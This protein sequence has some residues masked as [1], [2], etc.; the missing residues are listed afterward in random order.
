M[1]NKEI[2][3]GF[4][5]EGYENKNYDFVMKYVADNYID[6]SPANARSNK[7]AVGLLKCVAVMFDKLSIKVMDIF[8]E[9]EKVAIRVKYDAVHAG[10]CMGIPATGRHIS[11]EALEIFKVQDGKITE[12]WGYWPDKGI[13]EQLLN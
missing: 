1:T 13:E 9:N 8:E 2:V 12:S 6:H 11:F 5:I 10:E 3:S 4:F 7:D